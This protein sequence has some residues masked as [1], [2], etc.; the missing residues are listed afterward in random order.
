VALG[1]HRPPNWRVAV[2]VLA[3]VVLLALVITAAALK[4]VGDESDKEVDRTPIKVKGAAG[5]KGKE[6]SGA[7][8]ATAK[9]PA[10]KTPAAKKPAATKKTP[11]EA[12]PASGT[13]LV[14]RGDLYEWPSDLRAFTVVL[15]SA[16]DEASAQRFARDASKG[17]PAKIGVIRADDFKSLPKGFF[18]VFAGQY[19]DRATADKAAQRL[20]ARFSGGFPQL[21]ER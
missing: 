10:T 17:M 8:K 15:L 5:A 16:E 21:V 1:Y 18:V 6:Q 13:A 12:A 7:K 9:K 14:K 4:K 11:A 19:K 20:A 3:G 2:V